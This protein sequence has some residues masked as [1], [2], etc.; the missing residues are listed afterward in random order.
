MWS[1]PKMPE[2]RIACTAEDMHPYACGGTLTCH[3]CQGVVS[4]THNP[5]TCLFCTGVDYL[6]EYA[7]GAVPHPLADAEALARWKDAAQSW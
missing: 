4:A 5:A 2:Y 7:E 1:C 3:H 6:D